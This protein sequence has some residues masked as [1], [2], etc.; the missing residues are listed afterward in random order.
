MFEKEFLK[1][2]EY[3]NL[4]IVNT[5]NNEVRVRMEKQAQSNLLFF[6]K[7][8]LKDSSRMVSLFIMTLSK[9][10]KTELK[11]LMEVTIYCF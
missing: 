4:T 7:E 9:L 5:E 8:L 3:F 6:G 1:N 11:L 2:I 10:K